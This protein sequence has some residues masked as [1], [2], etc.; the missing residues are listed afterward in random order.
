MQNY[1]FADQL[2]LKYVLADPSQR[3]PSP[4]HTNEGQSLVSESNPQVK[5]TGTV[6]ETNDI[7]FIDPRIANNCNKLTT[8]F[9]SLLLDIRNTLKRK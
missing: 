4:H 2:G 7:L 6:S 9:A 5:G 8:S 1:L 3:P